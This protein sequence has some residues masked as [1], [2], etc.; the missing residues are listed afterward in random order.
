MGGD[1]KITGQRRIKFEHKEM[2]KVL[3]Q[4]AGHKRRT[5]EQRLASSL[6]TFLDALRNAPT[7]LNT[8]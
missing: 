6:L 2:R 5:M 3:E 8:R 1:M 7:P 4:I